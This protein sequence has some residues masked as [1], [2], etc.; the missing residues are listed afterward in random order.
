MLRVEDLHAYY[1]R[2]HIVQGVDLEIGKG[3]I[4]DLLGRN[5]VG[6]STMIKAIIG[7]VQRE[8][9]ISTRR[10]ATWAGPRAS[11]SP[12]PGCGYVPESRDIFPTLTVRQ[13]LLLGE[14]RGQTK[15]RWPVDEMLSLFSNLRERADTAGDLVGRRK[16]DADDLSDPG[17]RSGSDHDR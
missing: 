3:E 7:I 8:G 15:T 10:A 16:T 1:D 4:V 2:S 17:G 11:R 6:R 12:R 13:N 14:K 5:G 9:W